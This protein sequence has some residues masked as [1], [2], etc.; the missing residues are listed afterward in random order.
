MT[1]RSRVRRISL[2]MVG[3]R[4]SYCAS[5][6]GQALAE[7]VVGL[8]TL[9]VVFWAVALVGRYQD[10]TLQA[11]HA[12]RYA[13]FLQ[14]VHRFEDAE[15]TALVARHFFADAGKR[16]RTASGGPLLVAAPAVQARRVPDTGVT[17]LYGGVPVSAAPLFREWGVGDEGL[18]R[19]AVNVRARRTPYGARQEDGV[20]LAF[21]RATAILSGAGHGAD[22]VNVQQRLADGETA[23]RRAA[24]QSRVAGQAVAGRMRGVDDAWG[25]AEPTFDWLSAWRGLV[26]AD[27]QAAL[28]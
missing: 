12:S 9:V 13:A 19:A 25:R 24:R 1:G 11:A 15:L 21:E 20:A 27:R 23:W 5:Q 16:W 6:S 17:T 7:G 26:P 18:L 4:A 3:P 10:I 22:D 28:P 2:N 14:T 8:A